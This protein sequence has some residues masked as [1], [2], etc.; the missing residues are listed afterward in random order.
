MP[1]ARTVGNWLRR[2]TQDPLRPFIQLNQ[3]VVLDTVAQLQ[4]PPLTLDVDG[5]ADR[6][7]RAR[8]RPPE[9]RERPAEPHRAPALSD[10]GPGGPR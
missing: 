8:G 4:I 9:T 10:A 1:T 7:R 3:D 2:F 6:G 5:T